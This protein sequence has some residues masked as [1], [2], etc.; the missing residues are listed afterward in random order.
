MVSH[1][2]PAPSSPYLPPVSAAFTTHEAQQML[3]SHSTPIQPG[4]SRPWL[5]DPEQAPHP[6][7]NDL[8]GANTP[9]DNVQS[10]DNQHGSQ[11]KVSPRQEAPLQ[12]HASLQ[13][14]SSL[15]SPSAAVQDRSKQISSWSGVQQM[16]QSELMLQRQASAQPQYLP[17]AAAKHNSRPAD[18]AQQEGSLA[19]MSQSSDAQLAQTSVISSGPQKP[20]AA[21]SH[22][23]HPTAPSGSQAQATSSQGGSRQLEQIQ[24]ASMPEVGVE[25]EFEQDRM[26]QPATS[27]EDE[28]FE[29]DYLSQPESTTDDAFE[30]DEAMS[31]PS[32]TESDDINANAQ[33]AM[34]P[35][36][37][38]ASALC[39]DEKQQCLAQ[40]PQQPASAVGTDRKHQHVA[41]QSQQAASAVG[42]DSKHQHATPAAAH[43]TPLQGLA[44]KLKLAAPSGSGR[45]GLKRPS[46]QQSPE[47]QQMPAAKRQAMSPEWEQGP[48][49]RQVLHTARQHKVAELHMSNLPQPTSTAAAVSTKQMQHSGAGTSPAAAAADAGRQGTTANQQNQD[50]QPWQEPQATAGTAPVSYRKRP[51]KATRP[52]CSGPVFCTPPEP[53]DSPPPVKS[54]AKIKGPQPGTEAATVEAHQL[55]PRED[56][57]GRWAT[58]RPRHP[59]KPKHRGAHHAVMQDKVVAPAAV[60]RS[61]EAIAADTLGR[62]PVSAVDRGQA[63]SDAACLV[64][65][66][67]PVSVSQMFVDGVHTEW[68][69][70]HDRAVLL[71]CVIQHQGHPAPEV[72][73]ELVQQLQQLGGKFTVRQVQARFQ[74]LLHRFLQNSKQQP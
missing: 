46:R 13:Q 18:T 45:Q 24:L 58:K 19:G 48:Q 22:G 68:S 54:P 3:S 59:R 50:R 70:E 7:A 31:Q 71:V 69:S 63:T 61:S 23:D 62:A 36:W 21:S 44:A 15:Q 20:A 49:R 66:V 16:D 60:V 41:Q 14:D 37:Q 74:L 33:Q 30:L 26:S 35:S 51:R 40:Q 17:P 4:D 72:L 38:P 29:P 34:L 55:R 47:A 12:Q 39:T 11:Q 6:A 5:D 27:E 28:D 52:K 10:A 42:T 43:S 65:G 53:P 32:D 2:Q 57:V 64:D 73:N 25:E 1:Q 8:P 67:V 9:D 56:G